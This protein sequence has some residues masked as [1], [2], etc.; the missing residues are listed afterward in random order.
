MNGRSEIKLTTTAGTLMDTDRFNRLM[1][2]EDLVGKIQDNQVLIVLVHGESR[3]PMCVPKSTQIH[4][5][6]HCFMHLMKPAYRI[7]TAMLTADSVLH[8]PHRTLEE[9]AINN[10]AVLFCNMIPEL[11]VIHDN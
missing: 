1:V 8:E 7:S 11:A 5:L 10:G 6:A 2:A 3:I 9:C 4:H